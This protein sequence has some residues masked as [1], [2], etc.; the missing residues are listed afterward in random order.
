MKHSIG[1]KTIVYPAPVFVVGT[2]DKDGK[3]NVMTAAW[4]GICCS[5]PPCIAVS[6]REA[7][8]TYGNI[9]KRK[10]FTI[11]IPSEKY[12]K[13]TDFFGISSGKDVDKFTASGLTPVKSDLVDAP[14]VE[15]FPFVLE[16]KLLHTHKLGLHTQFVG[17]IIDIKVEEHVIGDKGLPDIEK[18]KPILFAPDRR[19]YYGI[20]KYL[21]RAFYIGKEI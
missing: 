3:P 19:T 15:E 1:A 5:D 21:K 2:Y 9:I 17:K 16:C 10:A 20:G 12:V 4:A 7:T 11:N 18:I 6:L 14:Y 8:Y 13:E